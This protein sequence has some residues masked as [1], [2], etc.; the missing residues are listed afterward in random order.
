[1]NLLSN[2]AM[3][4]RNHPSRVQNPLHDN[5]TNASEQVFGRKILVISMDSLLWV[6]ET[7]RVE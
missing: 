3:R 6:G 2:G 4:H 7:A 1:M 5:T